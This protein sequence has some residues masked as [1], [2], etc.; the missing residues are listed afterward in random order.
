MNSATIKEALKNFALNTRLNRRHPTNSVWE[1]YTPYY[2]PE[3]FESLELFMRVYFEKDFVEIE[4]LRKEK[5]GVINCLTDNFDY[6]F[7]GTYVDEEDLGICQQYLFR[8]TE[9]EKLVKFLS[10]YQKYIQEFLETI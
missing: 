7:D 10:V 8:F 2:F 6:E 1:I 9:E 3:P 4:V 5:W